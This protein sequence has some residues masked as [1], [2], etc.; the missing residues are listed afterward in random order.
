MKVLSSH[1][2]KGRGVVTIIDVL[3]P[4]L[5]SGQYVTDSA[6][7]RW[8]VAGIETHAMRSDPVTLYFTRE[9][10]Q[11]WRASAATAILKAN[12]GDK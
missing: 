7:R 11:A 2:I 8:Q 4:S 3:P 6:R 1:L 10:L 5:L 12:K 9:Q